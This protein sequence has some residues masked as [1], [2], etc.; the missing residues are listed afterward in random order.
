MERNLLSGAPPI[1]MCSDVSWPV[2]MTTPLITKVQ[3]YLAFCTTVQIA[4]S[5]ISK[6]KEGFK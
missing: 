5:F 4:G 3:A 1:K 6:V 2:S